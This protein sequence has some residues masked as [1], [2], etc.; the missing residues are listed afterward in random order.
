M[1]LF[2]RNYKFHLQNTILKIVLRNSLWNFSPNFK[3]LLQN[4]KKHLKHFPRKSLISTEIPLPKQRFEQIEKT[5]C[6]LEQKTLY[7]LV[8]PIVSYKLLSPFVKSVQFNDLIQK[9]IFL[10]RM[11]WFQMINEYPSLETIRWT[12]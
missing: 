4:F 1:L 11:S 8:R 9:N 10:T 7:A 5:C 2:E 12:F 3:N 6:F